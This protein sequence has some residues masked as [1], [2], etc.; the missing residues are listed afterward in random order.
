MIP[1][2][3][4]VFLLKQIRADPCW[5]IDPLYS[6]RDCRNPGTGI[7]YALDYDTGGV[8]RLGGLVLGGAH[9]VERV[10][11]SIP[12]FIPERVGQNHEPLLGPCS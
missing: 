6:G 11:T 10:L 12:E 7:G 3:D 8:G 4:V 5:E 1:R 2:A 9:A